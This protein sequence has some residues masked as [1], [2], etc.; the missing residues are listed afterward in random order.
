MHKRRELFNVN[1]LFETPIRSESNIGRRARN[2]IEDNSADDL[3]LDSVMPEDTSDMYIT[4]YMF[5]KV[6]L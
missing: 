6:S 2:L 1:D 5:D 3:E 4:P